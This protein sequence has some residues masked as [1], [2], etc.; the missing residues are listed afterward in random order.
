MV[1][2]FASDADDCNRRFGAL[3]AIK[4]TAASGAGAGNMATGYTL[5]QEKSFRDAGDF[6]LG[7]IIWLAS[8]TT[9]VGFRHHALFPVYSRLVV[10]RLAGDFR[11]RAFR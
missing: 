9:D 6:T 7:N 3:T 1:G 10:K 8:P 4:D 11:L 5:L 2:R